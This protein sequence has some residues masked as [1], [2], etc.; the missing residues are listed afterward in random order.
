MTGP[1]SKG[2]RAS[3]LERVTP[4]G[5]APELAIGDRV[6]LNSGGPRGLVV[7]LDGPE[8]TVAWGRTESVLPAVCLRRA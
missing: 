3:D 2:F 1:R 5:P 6:R 8:V 4:A 7:D